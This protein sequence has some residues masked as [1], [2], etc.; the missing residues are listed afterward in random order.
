MCDELWQSLKVASDRSA[1]FIVRPEP[2]QRHHQTL[3]QAF[4]YCLYV[5][6][7]VIIFMNVIQRQDGLVISIVNSIFVLMTLCLCGFIHQ[8]IT[9]KDKVIEVISWCTE[10]NDKKFMKMLLPDAGIRFNRTRALAARITRFNSLFFDVI[11]LT[12]TV[13]VS[14]VMQMIPMLRYQLPM[15]WHLPIKNYKNWTA[16]GICFTLQ[17]TCTYLM[18]QVGSFFCSL[19]IVFYMHLKEYL[20]IIIDGMDKVKR[21]LRYEREKVDIDGLLKDVVNMIMSAL[22]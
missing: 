22:R 8:L 6:I 12:S 1:L 20:E 4:C 17:L 2:D 7:I 14:I 10:P 11:T 3:F 16:F 15:P 18:S 5:I 21:K 19:L 13:F 9:Q